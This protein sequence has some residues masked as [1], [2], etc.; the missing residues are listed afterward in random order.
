MNNLAPIQTHAPTLSYTGKQLELIKKTVAADCTP[1]EFNLFIEVSRR[2]GLDP[3]RRQIYAVVYNKKDSEKRRM[4]IITGIDGYR[5]VAA[6]NRDYRP[7]STPAEF[8]TDANLKSPANPAGLIRAVVTC[9]KYGPDGQW[10]PVAGEAYWDEFA[11]LKEVAD[12]YDWIDT[13]ETW[14]DSGKPKK[15]KVPRGETRTEVDG[16]WKS[17]PHVMLAKCSEA[18]ALRRGWPEDLSGVYTEEEMDRS[19]VA[20]LSASEAVE[21]FERDKRLQITGGRDSIFVVWN[22]ADPMEAV[23]LGQFA[24]KATAFVRACKELPDLIGWEETN[25]VALQDFWAKSKADALELK[26]IIEARK[27]QI[28]EEAKAGA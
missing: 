28:V 6:R 14:P 1:D 19:R 3:F 21:L 23:P 5:S 17:M 9:Y 12:E 24:D 7:A 25:R 13:G 22:P 2:V 27:T 26:K 10:H 20:D 15:K 8:E 4:S 11:P 16:K 18:Q